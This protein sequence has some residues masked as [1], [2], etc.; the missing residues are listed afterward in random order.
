MDLEFSDIFSK[1]VLL[2]ES[3]KINKSR[4]IISNKRKKAAQLTPS[5]LKFPNTSE[6]DTTNA[7]LNLLHVH[8][9]QNVDK[10]VSDF[11]D[12]SIVETTPNI[13]IKQRRKKKKVV[14][15]NST[16]T[17]MFPHNYTSETDKTDKENSDYVKQQTEIDD[18]G[19]LYLEQI[20]DYINQDKVLDVN[21]GCQQSNKT[22]LAS[23]LD[24]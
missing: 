14:P 17:Q 5:L 23:N 2:P 1:T 22:H 4:T 18:G 11:L 24:R 7:S 15:K 19:S 6:D 16:L 3:P 9:P 13:R 20:L 21:V 8:T 10:N 12:S